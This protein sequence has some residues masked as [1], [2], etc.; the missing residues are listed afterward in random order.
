MNESMNM[1][2]YK[3]KIMQKP[4]RTM[5][6]AGIEPCSNLNIQ[7]ALPKRS[8]LGLTLGACTHAVTRET[9]GNACGSAGKNAA[10][11][12]KAA[13]KSAGNL[14]RSRTHEDLHDLHTRFFQKKWKV[15]ET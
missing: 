4:K 8:R 2:A 7:R 6:G 13:S 11:A 5:P 9:E 3:R 14:Q 15:P 12:M 1:Y 10:S